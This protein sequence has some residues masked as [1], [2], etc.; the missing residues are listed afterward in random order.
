MLNSDFIGYQSYED[1]KNEKEEI[2]EDSVVLIAEPDNGKIIMQGQEYNLDP[3]WERLNFWIRIQNTE[4]EKYIDL[5]LEDTDAS[6]ILW[7]LLPLENESYYGG[8][9]TGWRI[10]IEGIK[11]TIDGK[12]T[13]D[14]PDKN[15]YPLL[16]LWGNPGSSQGGTI[17]YFLEEQS[18][19]GTHKNEILKYFTE[20]ENTK[21]LEV[22]PPKGKTEILK[23]TKL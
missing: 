11:I 16:R 22:L 10:R 14:K 1:Y 23:I 5:K 3:Q 2:S 8:G 15:M 12:D 7:E 4:T 19:T 13:G 21:M 20:E 6:S 9:P 18:G 17:Y